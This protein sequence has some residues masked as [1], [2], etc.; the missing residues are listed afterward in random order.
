ME[1]QNKV[2]HY[3]DKLCMCVCVC[4]HHTIGF[5]GGLK[6]K[7]ILTDTHQLFY[8]ETLF[9]LYSKFKPYLYTLFG[10]KVMHFCVVNF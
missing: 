7:P 3:I 4:V 1:T 5:D 8:V 10:Y 2:L 9:E 6:Q